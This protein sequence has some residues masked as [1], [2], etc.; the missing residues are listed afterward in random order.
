MSD[1]ENFLDKLLPLLRKSE[2]KS[3]FVS[4]DGSKLN[5]LIHTKENRKRTRK[6]EY[7][8]ERKLVFWGWD[9]AN[10][11]SFLILYGLQMYEGGYVDYEFSARLNDNVEYNNY[12][13]FNGKNG[14]L[15]SFEAVKLIYYAYGKKP[16][17][18]PEMYYKKG[19][20]SYYYWYSDKDSKVKSFT[21]LKEKI[22]LPYFEDIKYEN[23][24]EKVK[25]NI[26]EF[27][28]ARH[29][30]EVLNLSDETATYF[31]DL[32]NILSNKNIYMRKKHLKLLIKRNPPK[33]IYDLLLKLGSTEV[34]SGL[35]LDLA[36]NRDNIILKEAKEIL[37]S[38]V[39][40][41][42]ENY[43]K[44]VRRCASI[45]VN[46][47]NEEI[48]IK[49]REEIQARLPEMD[50]HIVQINGKKVKEGTNLNGAKYRRYANQES[51]RTWCYDYKN[52]RIVDKTEDGNYK[53]NYYTNGI[54][55]DKVK[56]KDT[57][58][59]A[60]IYGFPEVIG[61]VAY[62]L[63]AP[64]LVYY[65]RGNSETKSLKYFQ[66]QIINIINDYAKHNTKYFIE[67]M[68]VL[69]TSYTENDCLGKI[70]DDFRFNKFIHV[71]RQFEYDNS[72]WYNHM[73]DLIYIIKNAKV[74]D[75]LNIC[76]KILKNTPNKDEVIKNI[77]Y[78]T[79]IK[80]TNVCH[81]KLSDIF[82]KELKDRLS[83]VTKFDASIMIA[84]IECET[85]EVQKL[86]EDYFRRTN[87][88]FCPSDLIELMFI[89]NFENLEGFF[90]EALLSLD[91]KEYIE[92]IKSMV[93]NS[94]RFYKAGLNISENVENI[95][96]N[97]IEKLEDISKE[98]KSELIKS[99]ST[100]FFGKT[101]LPKWI[102]TY[103][104]NI[105]FGIPYN[106]L[107]IL[108]GDVVL[109]GEGVVTQGGNQIISLVQ[110]IKTGSIPKDGD[111]INILEEGTSQMVKAL[112]E[113]FNENKK[114]LCN[115]NST[116]IIMLESDV[117][118]LNNLA[119]DIFN[120]MD[121]KDRVELHKMIIDSPIKKV[122]LFGLEKL[123]EDYKEEIPKEFVIQMLEHTSEFVKAYTSDKVE[124]ILE[125]LS[126]DK[127]K[128]LIHYIKT[129]LYLPNK[130]SKSK[131]DIYRIISKFALKSKDNFDVVES[132][133]LDIGGSN[134]IV[135]SERAL[136][137]LAGLRKEAVLIE[138]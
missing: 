43:T 108:V 81:K 46:S 9:K 136:V 69:L 137:A 45:Y 20:R 91:N 89:N 122:N 106:D 134:I 76:Y 135:D 83:K 36:K 28:F 103:I 138:G 27:K 54:V 25:D 2:G 48:K 42:G 100:Q 49:R 132:I 29:P 125:G 3:K 13:I 127:E 79:L 15:P 22:V 32:Y 70:P 109:N 37:E 23:A 74:F 61:K 60:Y 24:V 33:D 124:S 17:D 129:L 58:Q 44:G 97:C 112:L 72:I 21:K 67:A 6:K 115:R 16:E 77:S 98:E 84:L 18:L 133:L 56:V 35:F 121:I 101:N 78:K 34:I 71:Q 39:D 111:F 110:A 64:R 31:Y 85:E 57:I 7:E 10:N 12:C 86:C 1:K 66:R 41:G 114:E 19:V 52:R 119:K 80:L 63:D 11:P 94:N 26:K 126:K 102:E 128:V 92:F 53:P 51:L 50:L 73:D 99:L 55:L 104:K 62:Y 8:P 87:G 82:M 130:V 131:D 105:I 14:H 5:C 30:N 96:T 4:N 65:F 88:R 38:N 123:R 107:K 118:P 93:E 47:F 117:V 59:E 95:L 120:G 113:V 116:L 75:V 90:K 40:F 68:K